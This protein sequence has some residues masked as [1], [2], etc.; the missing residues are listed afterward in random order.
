[1]LEV[2]SSNFKFKCNN[3]TKFKFVKTNFIVDNMRNQQQ[4]LF[5]SDTLLAI[6]CRSNF[7]ADNIR[8]SLFS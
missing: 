8:I 2:T 1:M 5:L 7:S 6:I 4:Q 3:S